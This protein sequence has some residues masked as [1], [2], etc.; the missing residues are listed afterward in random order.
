MR[1]GVDDVWEQVGEVV[2]GGVEGGEGVADS[3]ADNVQEV[4]AG[5][6]E[7]E[8]MEQI[9]D[10]LPGEDDEGQEVANESEAA[11]DGD[12]DSIA[13]EPVGDH[14]ILDATITDVNFG[15]RGSESA[16]GVV[17]FHITWC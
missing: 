15:I 14:V 11:D 17:H 8:P 3:A 2:G 5:Q 1:E 6:S 16:A 4:E 9:L 12:Q 10:V 7:Q 13:P